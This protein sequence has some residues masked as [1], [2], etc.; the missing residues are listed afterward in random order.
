[1]NKSI[2]HPEHCMIFQLTMDSGLAAYKFVIVIICLYIL[3]D[4]EA[5]YHMITIV[6]YMDQR[7]LKNTVTLVFIINSHGGTI[8]FSCCASY[9]AHAATH[10][11]SSAE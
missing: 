8:S 9:V 4:V 11:N 5:C 7:N 1:M 6:A 10:P 2:G 3:C